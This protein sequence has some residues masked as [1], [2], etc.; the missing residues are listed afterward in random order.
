MYAPGTRRLIGAEVVIDKD[1]ASA[2]LAEELEADVFVMAT[3]V[4]AV[5]RDFGTPSQ[6]PVRRATPA[7]FRDLD[8][9]AGSMGPKVDAAITFAEHTGKPAAIGR[10]AEIGQVLAGV[11]GTRIEPAGVGASQP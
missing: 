7:E 2:L 5:Y 9:P 10:L 1:R 11:R 8:L 6:A 4:D 3:D